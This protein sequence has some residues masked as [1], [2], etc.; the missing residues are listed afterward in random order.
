MLKKRI[1]NSKMTQKSDM[2]IGQIVVYRTGLLSG[3]VQMSQSYSCIL[4]IFWT[5]CWT[6][7]P[8]M[9]I[10]EMGDV[11]PKIESRHSLNA[12]LSHY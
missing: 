6:K 2:D 3:L 8:A 11:E 1:Q 12:S 4:T 10:I 5:V 7:F 9:C